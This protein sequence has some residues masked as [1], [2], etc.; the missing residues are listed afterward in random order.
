[1]STVLITGNTGLLSQ[2]LFDMLVEEHKI[3]VT[4]DESLKNS[5][6]KDGKLH[7]YQTAPGEEKFRKLFDAYH[8]NAVLYISGYVDFCSGLPNEHQWVD[9]IFACCKDYSVEK[10]I[11]VSTAESQT[12]VSMLGRSGEFLGR[13]YETKK[14][15]EAAQ[16]EELCSYLSKNTEIKL[17]T[18]RCQYLAGRGGGNGLLNHIFEQMEDDGKPI[19][20]PNTSDSACDFISMRD[21]A[22]LLIQIF[23]E[24]E[25][26]SNEYY[27]I[28]GYS[29][30]WYEAAN[31]IALLN[32]KQ[33][34]EYTDVVNK[35]QF[36]DYPY[37]LRKVYGFVPMDDVISVLSD[38]YDAYRQ[39]T[40]LDN[41]GVFFK[42]REWITKHFKGSFKYIE[43]VLLFCL[44]EYIAQYT[45]TSVYFKIFDIRLL[46]IV[47]MASAHGL[48]VGV[49]AALLQCI[50]LALRWLNTGIDAVA[51]FY[52]VENWIPFVF[53]FMAGSIIGY[54]VD[55]RNNEADFTR[56]EMELLREKYSFL[57]RIYQGVLQNRSEYRHQILGLQD[58][59]GKIFEA[60]QTLD[61]EIS[62]QVLM[63][64][65]EVME[66]VLNNRSIAIYTLD[67]WQKFGRLV[68]CS[69]S[70]LSRLTKSLR[71]SDFQ[72]VYDT[73]FGGEVFSNTDF[74]EGLPACAYGV[75]HGD[76]LAFLVLV[77]ELSSEQY[78]IYF[79]N[80]F[81]ILCGLMQT[82]FLRANDYEELAHDKAYYPDTQIA[83]P[84]Y[85]IIQLH[86]QEDMHNAGMS[87]FILV[88]F[89]NS[90]INEIN[91][92]LTGVIRATD[93]IGT[94]ADG[95][96]YMILTQM[97]Q[98]NFGVVGKRLDERG[99]EYDIIDG[100]G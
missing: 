88:R 69:N 39:S 42:A 54:I 19:V 8:F 58:S 3:V 43:L 71:I 1:M 30:K 10:F 17:I 22:R 85:F 32:P 13:E 47:I 28:S 45:S 16:L 57:N 4:V 18:L 50:M 66:K 77:W 89:R 23:Q 24:S 37:E 61:S 86:I 98:S 84:D 53:Y 35:I 20:L 68:V 60:V 44:T 81:R 59:F 41:R 67:S 11:L 40:G 25:D 7:I 100:I 27:F 93:L 70:M 12:Y 63:K 78:G 79:N 49:I 38:Y 2:E 74:T 9:N 34:V 96:I 51:L 94:D 73:V 65:L 91:E 64:G 48:H 87:D 83:R 99:I 56:K 92:S 76:K 46:F 75:K 97:K 26:D 15:F 52:N 82:S 62:S 21:F 55:K 72:T 33:S 6:G 36:P 80:L 5:A 90:S 31:A 29:H 14:S 95:N